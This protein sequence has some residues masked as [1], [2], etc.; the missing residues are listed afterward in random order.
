MAN[1]PL[2]VTAYNKDIEIK[3]IPSYYSSYIAPQFVQGDLHVD[4][5]VNNEMSEYY[6]AVVYGGHSNLN[7][8]A[9]MTV[10]G[11]HKSYML[12]MDDGL[13]ACIGST[14]DA[15]FKVRSKNTSIEKE[16]LRALVDKLQE[17]DFNELTNDIEVRS[18]K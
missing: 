7:E 17:I 16:S 4:E 15:C 8:A 18:I 10:R 1:P 9:V 11:K 3:I 14:G 13:S 2:T 5:F 12:N 6:P